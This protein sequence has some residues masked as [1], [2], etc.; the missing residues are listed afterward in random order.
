M[1]VPSTPPG[2]I[3]VLIKIVAFGRKIIQ[4]TILPVYFSSAFFK[5]HSYKYFLCKVNKFANHDELTSKADVR[6]YTL[7]E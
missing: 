2:G 1:C 4:I 3:T 6:R 7:Q 5:Y